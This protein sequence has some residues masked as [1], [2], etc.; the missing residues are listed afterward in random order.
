M[1]LVFIFKLTHYRKTGKKSVN[2]GNVFNIL[3]P[4]GLCK[5]CHEFITGPLAMK[6]GLVIL[7][8]PLRFSVEFSDL[9]GPVIKIY[10]IAAI[11]TA[12]IGKLF[13][14]SHRL[15]KLARCFQIKRHESMLN[16]ISIDSGSIMVKPTTGWSGCVIH[17]RVPPIL[18]E[19]PFESMTNTHPRHAFF[20]TLP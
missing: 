8:I 4:S 5:P 11:V 3:S 15:A 18:H 13:R 6:H 9:A 19:N 10:N 7:A 12:E 14:K 20:Y 17:N 1:C 16:I 2:N